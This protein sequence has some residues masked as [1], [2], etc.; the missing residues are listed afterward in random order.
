MRFVASVML[1]EGSR[2]F[3]VV[4]GRCECLLVV[5]SGS[6]M[7]LLLPVLRPAA[8]S[9]QACSL[10]CLLLLVVRDVLLE[11]MQDPLDRIWDAINRIFHVSLGES[12]AQ[13]LEE[14]LIQSV[15]IVGLL[16]HRVS[17]TIV[18][19][20]NYMGHEVF[21]DLCH[22]DYRKINIMT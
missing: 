14:L 2:I 9:H 16:R 11:D 1:T 4:Y 19:K 15:P 22:Q 21:H 18:V 7:M 12:E 3:L 10:I 6:H 20:L 13:L 8:I 5:L 17:R